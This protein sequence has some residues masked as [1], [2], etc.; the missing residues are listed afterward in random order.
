MQKKD[1][2]VGIQPFISTSGSVSGEIVTINNEKYYK[3]SNYN[4]MPPFFMNIVSDS[5]L[6]MFIS[7]N[8]PLTAG[9]RNPDNALFPYYTDDKIHD[10]NEIILQQQ[11][12][13]FG[14]ILP[15][16]F[17]LPQYRRLRCFLLDGIITVMHFLIA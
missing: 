5:D 15:L 4:L 3:I 6:W 11:W 9:R 7:S 14:G 10:S 2:F 17:Q 8:G 13:L 1:I 16:I 12:L